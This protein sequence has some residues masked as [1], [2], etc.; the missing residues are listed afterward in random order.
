MGEGEK[1]PSSLHTE[2][3]APLRAPPST[4]Q[5]TREWKPTACITQVPLPLV[6]LE[7]ISSVW[8]LKDTALRSLGVFSPDLEQQYFITW[9]VEL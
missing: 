6:F 8:L 9:D 5:I 2:R 3:E 1:V 7:F 4:P